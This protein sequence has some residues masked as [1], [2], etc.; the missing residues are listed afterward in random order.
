MAD[1]KIYR[2]E[3]PNTLGGDWNATF[4]AFNIDTANGVQF[5]SGASVTIPNDYKDEH[6]IFVIHG[7]GAGAK[8]VVK[9]GNSYASADDLELN[10][11]SGK[12][13]F[14]TL[15]SAKFI[16]VTGETAE[17]KALIGKIVIELTNCEI[18]ALSPRI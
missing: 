18:M 6:T 1:L 17:E 11:A 7:T 9:A 14:F 3:K 12:Y 13:Q 16:K 2:T 15:D 5:T 10:V 4:D 8:A